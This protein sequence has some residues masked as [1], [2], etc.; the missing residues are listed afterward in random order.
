MLHRMIRPAEF[1]EPWNP[2][3]TLGIFSSDFGR[4]ASSGECREWSMPWVWRVLIFT[5]HFQFRFW[6]NAASGECREW[7][8]P[9]MWRVLIFTS[10]VQFRFWENAASGEC[11]EWSMPWVENVTFQQVLFSKCNFLHICDDAVI[12]GPFSYRWL[13]WICWFLQ[14]ENMFRIA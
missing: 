1:W 3:K 4:I 12:K 13:V 7:S 11:R 9:W 5:S 10:H 8:M 2:L 14:V 6:E